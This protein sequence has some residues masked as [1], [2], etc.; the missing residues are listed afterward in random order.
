ME[1]LRILCDNRRLKIAVVGLGY[2]GLPT[3]IAFHESG[4]DVNGVDI[5]ENVI[6]QL[7]LGNSPLKDETTSLNIPFDGERWNV[8]TDYQQAIPESDIVIITVPTPI[9][10]EKNPDLSYVE[11]AFAFYSILS[12]EEEKTTT[13]TKRE[14]RTNAKLFFLLF[15]FSDDDD[16]DDDG[17]GRVR[18]GLGDSSRGETPKTKKTPLC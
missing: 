1:K 18:D 4:F 17:S 5:S 10:E 12:E 3:A 2:V 11:K 6:E 14:K 16:D 9:D 13:T 15:S 8:T 7:K